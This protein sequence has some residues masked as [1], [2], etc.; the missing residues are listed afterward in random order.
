MQNEVTNI[1]E[2]YDRRKALVGDRYSRFK[3]EVIASTQER[4]RTLVLLLMSQGIVDLSGVKV[5][6]IGCGSGANLQEL[7][8]LGAKPGNLVGNELLPDRLEVARDMLP[9]ALR[10]FPGDASSLTFDDASFD[11]VYQSTVFTSILD[12]DLQRRIADAMWRWVKPGGGVLWYDFTF[13]N[14]ANPDVRGMPLNR[15]R[16]LFPMG[17]LSFQR[18]TLAPPISRRLCSIHPFLYPLFNTLPFLRTHV[19]CW[20]SKNKD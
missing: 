6:E 5:L 2:R 7:L 1:A 8:I 20:I 17:K 4:Q 11:I 12:D 19:L 10:L 14:P 15:V 3:P 9:Q 13:N 16:S 18:V